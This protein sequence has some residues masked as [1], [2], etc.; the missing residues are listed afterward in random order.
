MPSLRMITPQPSLPA[1]VLA[2]IRRLEQAGF[3]AWAVG[4]CV[5]DLFLGR[6][7]KDYDLTTSARPEQVAELFE[8]TIYT[9][10]QFGGVTVVLSAMRLEVTTYRTESRYTDSRHPE[11]VAFAQSIE[12]D[13]SRRDFTIG[14]IC[15]HPER[16]VYDP[17]NGRQDIQNR[18]LRCVGRPEGR[19][20]EDALRILRAFRLA[21][22]LGFTIEAQTLAAAKALAPSVQKVAAERIAGELCRLLLSPSPQL[23]QDLLQAGGL[24]HLGL[25]ACGQLT[26]LNT[27]PQILPVRLALLLVLCGAQPRQ[28][29]ASLRLSNKLSRETAACVAILTNPAHPQD[30]LWLKQRL[31]EMPPALL[32]GALQARAVQTGVEADLTRLEVILQAGEPYLLRHLAIDGHSLLAMGLPAQRIGGLLTTLLEHVRKNPADNTP[33]TLQRLAADLAEHTAEQ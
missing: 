4:G 16:G 8:S 29:C 12:E 6:T 31:A 3:E 10:K 26:P 30:A 9:G 27:C 5:R 13:V 21:A 32:V 22:E 18:L 23:L 7:P 2:V 25:H 28:V 33:T 24:A 11:K 1:P 14:A 20:A 19:F 15:L 17:F